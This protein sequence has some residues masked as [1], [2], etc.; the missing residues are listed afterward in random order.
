MVEP[1]SIADFDILGVIKLTDIKGIEKYVTPIPERDEKEEQLYYSRSKEYYNVKTL[2]E[3]KEEREELK[4]LVI[5]GTSKRNFVI[6]ENMLNCSAKTY[7]RKFEEYIM[8]EEEV[9]EKYKKEMEQAKKCLEEDTKNIVKILSG[10]PMLEV[11]ETELPGGTEN[12]QKRMIEMDNKALIYL[13]SKA[14]GT[15]EQPENVQV[16]NPGYGSIL[17]GPFLKATHGYDYTNYLK[18]RY[19]E[20]L[21]TEAQSLRPKERVS[22]DEVFLPHKKILLIDD[23]VGTGATIESIKEELVLEGIQQKD[24]KAGGI[25]YNWRNYYRI[26]KGEKDIERFKAKDYEIMTQI[27]YA[28]HKLYEHAIDR[29]LA[30]TPEKD[31][32]DEYLKEKAYHK[33][34][35]SDIQGLM[36]RGITSAGRVGM[37]L[38]E[39]FDISEIKQD[40]FTIEPENRDQ[41]KPEAKE[42]LE[43]MLKQ[44]RLLTHKEVK[45]E[46][47]IKE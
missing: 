28:G 13:F 6:V 33:E 14:I 27:N 40:E 30:I 2:E 29:L 19:I 5:R 34:G 35:K 11:S 38:N 26:S 37:Q 23:N 46:D 7:F 3:L 1:L 47:Y 43:E 41:L 24:I 12:S 44:F 15:E 17:I 36:Q 8:A 9:K 31:T 18:S 42:L 10:D 21:D 22:N 45:K 4:K 39:R 16:V 32:Y 25:Q 20:N